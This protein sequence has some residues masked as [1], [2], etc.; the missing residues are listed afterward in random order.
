MATVVPIRWQGA[1]RVQSLRTLVLAQSLAWLQN[2]AAT[3]EAV[4]CAVECLSADRH[5]ASKT[6]DGWLSMAGE[7]GSVWWRV[8]PFAI[9]QLG[10]CLV[11]T[12]VS[13]G[14]GLAAGIGR[15][16]LRDL[17]AQ[18]VGA[19]K[20]SELISALRPHAGTLDPRH[21]VVG[22]SWA[23]DD[24]RVELYFDAS[25]CDAMVPSSMAAAELTSR[26]EAI[27][28]AQV[29]LH[30]VLDLG[31]ASLEDTV[32]LRPGEVIR[33]GIALNQP[34]RV[35]TESGATVFAGALVANENQRALRFISH[36]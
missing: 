36:G 5:C 3:P 14:M 31:L 15:R 32:V 21:G 22:F 10:R 30:A 9:E 20:A 17:S 8:S 29:T 4:E 26:S 6:G 2:W 27:G 28:P 12:R 24:A 25:L 33:T 11:G 34:V 13:D 23:L 16:A 35:Q 18:W 19:G 7:Q 1:T